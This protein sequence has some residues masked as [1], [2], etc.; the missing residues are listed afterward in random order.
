MSFYADQIGDFCSSIH[1]LILD[2]SLKGAAEEILS[3]WCEAAGESPDTAAAQAAVL[4]LPALGL[5]AEILK[6]APV[7]VE[8]FLQYLAET[9]MSPEA[10]ELA[11][12]VDAV[13][14][15]FAERV[16]EDGTVRGETFRKNYTNVGRNDPCPCGSGKKFKKCCAPLLQ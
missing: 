14:G 10:E 1:Y 6:S 12:A 2:S 3:L 5:P 9:G 4:S 8:S 11:K 15:K 7:V 13:G 16:R